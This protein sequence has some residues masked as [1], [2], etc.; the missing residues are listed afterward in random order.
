MKLKKAVIILSLVFILVIS[1]NNLWTIHSASTSSQCGDGVC[2]VSEETLGTCPQ[3]CTTICGNC[4]CEEAE[5]L[6]CTSDCEDGCKAE[7][8]DEQF[9][10]ANLAMIM[11]ISVILLFY[12]WS[13][14]VRW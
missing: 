6:T 14:H 11:I 7:T 10:F 5:V 13:N 9:F 4:V 3:D 12:I 1:L 2:H 8:S